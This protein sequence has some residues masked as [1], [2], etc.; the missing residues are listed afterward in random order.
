[1]KNF[2]VYSALILALALGTSA[3][4]HA[5][6]PGH[7]CENTSPGKAPVCNTVAPEVDPGMAVAG[8]SLLGGTLAMVRSRRRK[9]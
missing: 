7:G 3:R 6:D 4:A 1:M 8:L 5:G 9:Q 2:L